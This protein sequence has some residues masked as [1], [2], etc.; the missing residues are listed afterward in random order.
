MENVIS[1]VD[2]ALRKRVVSF[3]SLILN[4]ELARLLSVFVLVPTMIYVSLSRRP[5]TKLAKMSLLIGGIATLLTNV[6]RQ[7]TMK[8]AVVP[9]PVPAPLPA[10]APTPLL[11][12][13]TVQD[14]IYI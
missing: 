1:K 3:D 9:S 5:P 7:P 14:D 6:E 8:T 11:D 13:K 12:R 2:D 10:P 4:P